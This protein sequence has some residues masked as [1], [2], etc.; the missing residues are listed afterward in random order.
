M[1]KYLTLTDFGVFQFWGKGEAKFVL[2]SDV[3]SCVTGFTSDQL[4][5]LSMEL[6]AQRFD[7]EKTPNLEKN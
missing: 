3:Q 1:N 4:L 6:R 7:D 2:P 5:N